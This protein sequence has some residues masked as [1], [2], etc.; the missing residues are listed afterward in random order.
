MGPPG[1]SPHEDPLQLSTPFTS[2]LRLAPG[3]PG[4]PGRESL[5]QW[6]KIKSL[7]GTSGVYTGTVLSVAALSLV[8]LFRER[9]FFQGRKASP[10]LDDVWDV[11]PIWN[12]V[13]GSLFLLLYAIGTGFLAFLLLV[14]NLCT[15]H[16]DQRVKKYR[17]EFYSFLALLFSDLLAV[18]LVASARESFE[19]RQDT[20][21]FESP[22][23]HY[24]ILVVFGIVLMLL[25]L[26]FWR[27]IVF[28]EAKD[29]QK[30]WVILRERLDE[31][32]MQTRTPAFI[33]MEAHP[34][35]EEKP[36]GCID[37]IAEKVAKTLYYLAKITRGR[38]KSKGIVRTTVKKADAGVSNGVVASAGCL[39]WV[40]C[41]Q[42]GWTRC[43]DG[44]FSWVGP[45]WDDFSKR[46][47]DSD[48]KTFLWRL[49]PVVQVGDKVANA[50]RNVRSGMQSYVQE[51]WDGI[52]ED[53]RPK[54]YRHPAWLKGAVLTAAVLT[55]YFGLVLNALFLGAVN[56][57]Y[58]PLRRC[59]LEY[60]LVASFFLRLINFTE[61][62]RVA[63]S[64]FL[65]GDLVG[66]NAT[67]NFTTLVGEYAAGLLERL[68]SELQE[69]HLYNCTDGEHGDPSVLLAAINFVESDLQRQED[70]AGV[71]NPKDVFFDRTPGA[72]T[73]IFDNLMDNLR[74]SVWVGYGCGLLVSLYTLISV[75]RQYKK[76]SLAIRSGLFTDLQL[77]QDMVIVD[78]VVAK[79]N[80]KRVEGVVRTMLTDR[81]WETVIKKY[82][83]SNA[84]FFF[85]ILV[86]TAVLQL[87]VFGW[88]VAT[89][90]AMIASVPAMITILKPVFPF[91][92]ALL[93][94]W[95][96]NEVIANRVVAE[97]MLVHNYDVLHELYFVLFLLIYT[98]VYTVLGILYAVWRLAMLSVTALVGVNRL[99]KN[100][101]TIFKNLDQGHNAFWATILMHHAFMDAAIEGHKMTQQRWVTVISRA[102]DTGRDSPDGAQ[103]ANSGDLLSPR[104]E[105]EALYASGRRT[106]GMEISAQGV[107]TKA[108]DIDQDDPMITASI[109]KWIGVGRDTK[110]CTRKDSPSP[111]RGHTVLD[112]GQ[113]IPNPGGS[114]PALSLRRQDGASGSGGSGLSAESGEWPGAN[115]GRAPVDR[116][117]RGAG[118]FRVRLGQ[119]LALRARGDGVGNHPLL[120]GSGRADDSSRVQ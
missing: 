66:A 115:G 102:R 57:I 27:I 85:G 35:V 86:S 68:N 5:A 22:V 29:D 21:K 13:L 82:P 32:V 88:I 117:W 64:P 40:C 103:P 81:S 15:F 87:L 12:R 51:A 80:L 62:S 120:D 74:W 94:M 90:F 31:A 112:L 39:R 8:I 19:Y 70:A 116:D 109:Q 49:K 91:V 10:P 34:P 96:L 63:M 79:R 23:A 99:D 18:F 7:D 36:M 46:A 105:V 42:V 17:W 2:F 45:C 30:P 6:K 100:L 53:R 76:I 48:E 33:P 26:Q 59:I 37:Y 73:I 60:K 71:D 72:V 50:I 114:S 61:G 92:L 1:A 108:L 98:G 11:S 56:D 113:E 58:F 118:S 44:I 75:L 52:K 84:S 65:S 4:P 28:N 67:T 9:G 104:D 83:I 69:D 55:I 54:G 107:S 106:D 41:L 38:D 110:A 16:R 78:R 97:N 43:F 20:S 14:P 47:Q 119:G 95:F 89:M 25:N 101:F 111:G 24:F 77:P 3:P 93:V